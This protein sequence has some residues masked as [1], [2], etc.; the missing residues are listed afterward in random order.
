MADFLERIGDLSPKHLALLAL[1]LQSKLDTL[2]QLQR[3]PIAIIGLGCRF[4]GASGPE[5]FWQLLCAGGDAITQVPADRWPIDA[6]YDPNPATPGKM[7]TRY[8]GFLP[9]I[10]HFDPYFFGISPREATSMDPQQRLLLEVS[11]EALEHAGQVPAQLAGTPTGVFIGLS[12]SDYSRLLVA[13]PGYIDAYFGTGNVYSVTAGR[14]SYFLGLHGPSLVVDTACSSALVAV[15]LA[16][17]SLRTGECRMALAGGV[18]LMLS[19]AF[20]IAFSKAHM[21]AADGHCK[22]FDAAA[23]GYVRGEGGGMVV[24]K[25]LTD[26]QADGDRILAL[27]RGTAV[28]QDGHSNGLTAPN[29]LAQEALLRT[30]L[31]QARVAPADVSY[32]EAHGTGTALGDPIEVQALGAVLGEGRTAANRLLLGSVKTNIGHLEA[33]AGIA[34]LIKVVLALQH[35]ELPPHLHLHTPNPHIAWDQLPVSVPTERTAWPA[36]A[37]RRVAGVSAFGF[38]GTNAHVLVE[39]A[40]AVPRVGP[41][42]ERP[43]HLLSLSAQSREALPALAERY[44]QQLRGQSPEGLADVCFTAN[45]GRTQFAHRLA[46]V[47]ESTGQLRDQLAGWMAGQG[48]AGVVSGTARGGRSAEVAFLFTGQGAQYVGMGRQ[49]YETQPTFRQTLERC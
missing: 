40:P 12:N 48:P 20:Y 43:W 45:V 2:E 8:G 32:V 44:V 38:S 10:D 30:A 37:R 11:W 19:P 17:Q 5:T 7:S 31:A 39:E 13:Y 41:V 16:C 24:L 21:L 49:L 28:N 29:G 22:T 27:V 6:Y 15:H 4:P 46:V 18:N 1:E 25:R 34:G 14:I 26:A 3:E 9:C 33:A 36:G 47:T 42:V 23:D 35:Q